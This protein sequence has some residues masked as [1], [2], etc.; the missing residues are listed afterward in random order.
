M[1]Y[2]NLIFDLD[3]TLVDS[4]GG[5]E[6]STRHALAGCIPGRALPPLRDLVGP[7]IAQM[8][9]R[10]WPDLRPQE[11]ERLVTYFRQHY[12]AEGCLASELYPGV[13]ETLRELADRGAQM[14]VLTNK[15]RHASTVILEHLG[16]ASHFVALVSPD[17][18]EPALRA[19]AEGAQLLEVKYA[20]DPASTMVIGDGLDDEQ[21]ANACGFA[22]LVAAYG[23]GSAAREAERTG[24]LSAKTFPS[25][26]A[27]VL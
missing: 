19:K 18:Q 25:I 8:F 14:F 26:L 27:A 16:I 4:L 10:A 2:R 1:R 22:F 21:A 23:Y 15:P 20:L 24:S 9:A 6:A 13:R 3:G 17:S 5:I 7:P 11:I 12:D